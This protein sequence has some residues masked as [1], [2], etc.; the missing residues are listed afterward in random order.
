MIQRSKDPK[1]QSCKVIKKWRKVLKIESES[2][3]LDFGSLDHFTKFTKIIFST[4]SF[5]ITI[6]IIN[7]F[8]FSLST[9]L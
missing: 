8:I 4:K 6:F 9:F 3:D 1:I 7:F 5:N 2:M